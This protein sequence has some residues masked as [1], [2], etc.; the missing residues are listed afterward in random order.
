MARTNNL[1]NFLTDVADSIRGKTGKSDPIP[2]EDFDTEIASIETGGGTEDIDSELNTYDSELTTQEGLLTNINT[3][4]SNKFDFEYVQDGLV[5]WFDEIE[6]IEESDERWHSK[7]G[8]DYIYVSYRRQ[9]TQTNNPYTKEAYAPLIAFGEFGFSNTVDY[10]QQGY[11]WEVVGKLNNYNGHTNSN[12]GWLITPNIQYCLGIGLTSTHSTKTNPVTIDFVN[13][14]TN[15]TNDPDYQT[16][17]GEY[18]GASIYLKTPCA[19]GTYGKQVLEASMHGNPFEEATQT[20][21]STHNTYGNYLSFLTYYSNDYQASGAIR[22][23]RIY[24]RK[25]TDAEVAYNHNIDKIRFNL[26]K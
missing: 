14:A 7:V 20:A 19:R 3:I 4:L 22:C 1:T 5:A 9:G 17:W 23:I 21:S 26:S 25:L 15:L 6:P 11:T 13:G 10:Y 12:S 2:C 16:N 18:F 8:N 24:N